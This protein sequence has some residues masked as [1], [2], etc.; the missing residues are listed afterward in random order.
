MSGKGNLGT[1]V[2][3]I[4]QEVNEKQQLPGDYFAVHLETDA[5][6]PILLLVWW[7]PCVV[8]HLM[9]LLCLSPSLV[10]ASV[11]AVDIGGA[12]TVPPPERPWLGEHGTMSV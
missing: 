5:L 10:M 8:S 1:L 6:S 9:C 7:P 2:I 4:S 12:G 11:G 3:S